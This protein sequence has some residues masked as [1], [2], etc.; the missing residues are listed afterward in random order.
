M[1]AHPGATE[2]YQDGRA[3][4]E[5]YAGRSEDIAFYLRNVRAGMSVLEYGAGTGRLTF[6]MAQRGVEVTAVDL[7]A[8]MLKELKGRL[9]MQPDAARTRIRMV[10]GDM[11]TLSLKARYD[12]VVVGFH[13][14]CHLYSHDDVVKFLARARAHLKPEGRLLL[15]VPMP[16]IDASGYDVIS[17]VCVTT[18]EGPRGSELLTQ[19]WYG[20]EELRMHLTFGGFHDVRMFGDF[21]RKK[22][23]ADTDFLAVSAGVAKGAKQTPRE[24]TVAR[25]RVG[26]KPARARRSN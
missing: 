16:H 3:Y 19:R 23:D 22:P 5:R 18:M 17:Q 26:L 7:S 25:P 14:F 13:T 24:R 9:S 15:D 10:Q 2:H 12:R 6:P 1:K 8:P 21:G 11:R 4:H 20:P